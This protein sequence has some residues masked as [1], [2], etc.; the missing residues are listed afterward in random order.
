MWRIPWLRAL[1]RAACVFSSAAAL[2]GT[3]PGTEPGAPV[4]APA[5]ILRLAQ[6]TESDPEVVLVLK[7]AEALLAE[8]K[9]AE[10]YEL[11]TRNELDLAGTPSFDYLLG[12]AALDSRRP[13]DAAFALERVVIWQ[14]DFSG[15][16]I[17][18]ARARF[19]SGEYALARSQFQYLLTQSPPEQT[20]TVIERYLD[21]ISERSALAGSRFSALAQFGVGYDSNANGST[22]EQS[23][24]GFT[25]NPH[26]VE[27]E[28]SFGELMLELG[29]TVALSATSGL[30]SNAQI[31]HRANVDAS[32][33]DQTAVTLGTAAVW[34]H[35]EY[36]FSVGVEG[37][38][39]LLDGQDH[40][41]GVNLNA[42]AARRFGDYEGAL[43][44]RAGTLEYQEPLLGILDADRYL[45]GL[46]VTRLNI[47]EHSGRLGLALFGGTDDAKQA[48]SPHG[49]DRLGVRLFGSWLLRP[50]STLYAEVSSLGTDYDGAFFG[51]QRK[52]DQLGFTL[53]FDF[54]NFPAAKWSVAPRLRYVKND[55]NISLYEY[56]RF[57]A[58]VSVRRG[59]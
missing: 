26:N 40:E 41:R 54:Q 56:D 4:P 10:A 5:S 6:L 21:A 43:S 24:L 55:S 42:G 7:Q 18:L 57:E 37:Y 23:F 15:A 35:G 50:Q 2:C 45:A 30:I 8:G 32:F 27:I 22:S 36:G 58:V 48:G 47:G 52:D 34:A 59:F 29:H 31:T 20:R 19:E 16:R 1:A 44:L 39:G 51:G 12:V 9:S 38:A 13:K 11:L 28:S 53:V 49:N 14:P 46:S 17:E 3:R 33:I 25:L